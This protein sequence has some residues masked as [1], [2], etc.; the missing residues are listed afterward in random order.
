MVPVDVGPD[1]ARDAAARE[2]SDPAYHAADPSLP[3]RILAWLGQRLDDLFAGIASVTHGGLP[4]LVVLAL[5][6]VLVVVIIRLRVGRIVR[7][8]RIPPLFE[9]RPRSADDHRRAAES[10][11][12]AGDLDE[13]VRERFR[14][15]VRELEQRG[16]LDRTSGRTVDEIA[17]QAGH[18]LPASADALTTG[19]AIVDDVL[20]GGR[21]STVDEYDHLAALDDRVRRERVLR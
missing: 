16:V 20:Y 17:A 3:Q 10:A 18:A 14:A 19:A 4:G 8:A 5:L 21:P 2:L 7:T 6:A 11:R 9:A 12:S 13:A 1:E 15:I